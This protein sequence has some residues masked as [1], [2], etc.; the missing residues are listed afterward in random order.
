MLLQT[1]ENGEEQMKSKDK[2][3]GREKV[4]ERFFIVD[5]WFLKVEEQFVIN[6]K[7]DY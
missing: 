7:T 4:T 6:F 3:S 5:N 1:R 2:Q